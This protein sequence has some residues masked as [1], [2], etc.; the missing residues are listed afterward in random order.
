MPDV[1]WAGRLFPKLGCDPHTGNDCQGGQAL[2]PCPAGGCQ[3][4]A[5]TKIEFNYAD[6]STSRDS[7]YDISLVDGYNLGARFTAVLWPAR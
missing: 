1:G 7:W 6:L 4:A 3:P 2:P 5:T